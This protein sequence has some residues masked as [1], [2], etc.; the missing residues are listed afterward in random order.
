M[1]TPKLTVP[2]KPNSA[3]IMTFEEPRAPTLTGTTGGSADTEKS[4]TM[5]ETTTECDMVWLV[6]VTFAL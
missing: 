2:P 4:W 6:A 1:L 5:Y 3:V